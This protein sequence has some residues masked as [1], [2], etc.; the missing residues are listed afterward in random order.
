MNLF[1]YDKITSIELENGIFSSEINIYAS[2]YTGEI[3]AI[4]K[5]K[6]EQIVLLVKGKMEQILTNAKQ[7]MRATIR[8]RENINCR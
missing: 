2:G 6:A 1:T 7:E 3:E 5:D 4:P 8:R